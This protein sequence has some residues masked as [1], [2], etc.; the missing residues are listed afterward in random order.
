MPLATGTRQ[1]D[2][3]ADIDSPPRIC[4]SCPVKHAA[5]FAPR[6]PVGAHRPV[7]WQFQERRHCVCDS[8]GPR[9][10]SSSLADALHQAPSQSECVSRLLMCSPRIESVS[11]DR[12][13]SHNAL[14]G[15]TS[16]NGHHKSGSGPRLYPPT[17]VQPRAEPFIN[18]HTISHQLYA[19]IHRR[20]LRCTSI[21][22]QRV[23]LFLSVLCYD[24][25]SFGTGE[26][27][28]ESLP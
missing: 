2:Q 1:N 8:N 14:R 22:S 13:L 10:R 6:L 4:K 16:H 5:R 23:H 3:T 27:A 15:G 7:G 21:P 12:D 26:T 25:P 20:S 28:H 11:A 9:P 24:Q 17:L 19:I 18:L